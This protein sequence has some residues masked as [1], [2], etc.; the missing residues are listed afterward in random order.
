MDTDTGKPGREGKQAMA[1]SLRQFL[2]ECARILDDPDAPH[3]D[4]PLMLAI[5]GHGSYGI[6]RV[7]VDAEHCTVIILTD[8]VGSGD[9]RTWVPLPADPG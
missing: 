8:A 9:G 1:Y 7:H 6:E 2:D 3:P 5:A 4:A